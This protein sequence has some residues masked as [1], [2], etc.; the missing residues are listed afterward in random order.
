MVEI[1]HLNPKI[2]FTHDK[3]FFEFL[4]NGVIIHLIQKFSLP[5]RFPALLGPPIQN[6]STMEE[7]I[8]KG[9]HEYSEDDD[10]EVFEEE[11]VSRWAKDQE[12][13]TININHVDHQED[14]K[15]VAS[16]EMKLTKKKALLEFRCMVEDAILGNYI[17]ENSEKKLSKKEKNKMIEQLREITL[18]GVPLLP[19]KSHE[20][21]D[22]V[23]LKFLKAKDF[24]VQEAFKMLQKTLKW[25]KD[26]KID[27]ILEEDLLLNLEPGKVLC[28][29]S[30]DKEGNPLCY[31]MYGA[32]KDKGFYKRVLGTE[33]DRE[34]YLRWRIQIMER[35][36]KKLT[37]KAG[38]ADAVL[39]ITDFK[40][41]PV[42]EMKELRS[43]T[44][45]S[46]LLLQSYYP[47]MVH[48]NVSTELNPII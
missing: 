43:V 48:K 19:S 30:A 22:T 31:T 44:K 32:F 18:W 47:E 13:N 16:I 46:F 29:N 17:L 1:P 9:S 8:E 4:K 11:K 33:E 5:D 20:S 39:Q 36:I 15:M 45:K 23:L 40:N 37:L 26:N 21:T 14:E 38:E 35:M 34:K 24:K 2:F 6:L 41:L 12:N 10:T 42:P 25:R 28:V 27:D 3:Y 7:E